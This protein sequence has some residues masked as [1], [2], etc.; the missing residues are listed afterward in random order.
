MMLIELLGMVMLEVAAGLL[1]IPAELVLR[2]MGDRAMQW[3]VFA[4]PMAAAA[5]AIRKWRTGR[6]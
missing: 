1:E 5:L 3:S 4:A 2:W 6:W